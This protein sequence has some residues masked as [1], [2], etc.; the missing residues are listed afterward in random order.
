MIRLVLGV[1]EFLMLLLVAVVYVIIIFTLLWLSFQGA[2]LSGV[3][4]SQQPQM[5]SKMLQSLMDMGFS[6]SEIRQYT[7]KITRM[8]LEKSKKTT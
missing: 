4:N 5:R 3:G 8:L 6:V 2:K 1:G 7:I